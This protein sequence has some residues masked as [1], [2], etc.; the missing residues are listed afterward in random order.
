M[1]NELVKHQEQLYKMAVSICKSEEVAQDVLQDT[2]LKLHDSGKSFDEVNT[3]YI[4][5]T[6]KSIFLDSVKSSSTKNRFLPTE[7]IKDIPTETE[8][9]IVIV[10]KNLTTFEKL[11]INAL[12]GR[13]ITNDKNE[14]VKKIEGA[15]KLK[16][17]RETGIPYKTIYKTFKNLK[18]KICLEIQ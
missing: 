2:Y 3:G 15:N 9:E 7:I 11:L 6:M 1:L 18:N 8:S 14:I 16:L 17:A 4:Y 13:D 12:F 10:Y 5:F